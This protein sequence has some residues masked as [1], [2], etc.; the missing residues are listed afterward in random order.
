[1]SAKILVTYSTKYG[2][3]QGV[4]ETIAKV[5]SEKY[6]VVDLLPS[7]EVRSLEDYQ[8]V[9]MGAPIYAGSILSD[10]IKFINRFKDSLERTPSALFIL[11][12][13]DGSPQELRGVQMQ[14]DA[15]RK[16]KFSWYK[17]T[18]NKIFTGALD[19]SKLRFPDSLIK[20]YR[21]TPKNSLTSKDERDWKAINAW[22]TSLP[23]ILGLLKT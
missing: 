7:R 19:L 23:E 5:L 2:S 20:L 17:P 1:M 9:I 22:A 3:T 11:G 6:F 16:K 4:A 18:T 8:A 12:P 15:N 21:S 14:V 13:L 10:S